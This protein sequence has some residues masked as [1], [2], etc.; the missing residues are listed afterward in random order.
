MPISG[1]AEGESRSAQPHRLSE[2]RSA[3][4]KGQHV[5]EERSGGN[6]G[7]R[8]ALSGDAGRAQEAARMTGDCTF[9]V[10]R[11]DRSDSEILKC[12]D[13]VSSVPFVPSVV[14]RFTT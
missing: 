12:G 13:E 9:S 10:F 8:D 5:R 2:R 1:A 11:G 3:V 6:D 7:Q 4:G 14:S